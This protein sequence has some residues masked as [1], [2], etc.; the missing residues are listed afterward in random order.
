MKRLQVV[1]QIRS[2]IRLAAADASRQKE[3]DTNDGN[4]AFRD[5]LTVRTGHLAATA[6]STH[7]PSP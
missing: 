1:F 2:I 6:S 7:S 4:Y 3:E 5:H